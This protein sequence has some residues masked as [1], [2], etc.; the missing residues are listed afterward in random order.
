MTTKQ[1]TRFTKRAARTVIFSQKAPLP[2][3]RSAWILYLHELERINPDT[4]C[5]YTLRR[6]LDNILRWL[7]Q[8]K[9]MSK[10]I[11]LT[12]MQKSIL[13]LLVNQGLTQQQIA[14]RLDRSYVSV[15]IRLAE[16]KQ[17]LDADTVVQA[18]ARAV[19]LGLVN[20]SRM[21]E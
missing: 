19:E 18:A 3:R 5:P 13:Y 1:K 12:P 21:E 7:A 6:A 11:H 17:K 10:I 20:T 14:S 15:R 16:I 2:V 4:G 9:R 8:Q